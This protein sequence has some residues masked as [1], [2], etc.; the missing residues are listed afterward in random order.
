M[1][2]DREDVVARSLESWLSRPDMVNI[3]HT[4]LKFV[5]VDIWVLTVPSAYSEW[6]EKHY[7]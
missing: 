4:S 2:G 3:T 7:S 1:R 6:Q 5:V